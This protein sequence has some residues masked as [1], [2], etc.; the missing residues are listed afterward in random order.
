MAE[1]LPCKERNLSNEDLA[2]SLMLLMFL[3]IIQLRKI[4]VEFEKGALTMIHDIS[5]LPKSDKNFMLRAIDGLLRDFKTQR[6][7]AS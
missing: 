4:D 6:A 3:S 7:Y 1:R 2:S 5:V